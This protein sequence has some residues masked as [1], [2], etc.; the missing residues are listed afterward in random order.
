MSAN[1]MQ[2]EKKRREFTLMEL[3]ESTAKNKII[4]KRFRIVLPASSYL[5]STHK[6]YGTSKC[7]SQASNVT[8]KTL[9]L[10]NERQIH[11]AKKIRANLRAALRLRVK[12]ESPVYRVPLEIWSHIFIFCLPTEDEYIDPTPSAAPLVLSRVNGMWRAAATQTPA[13]WTSIRI[14]LQGQVHRRTL[15]EMWF[16]RAGDLPLSIHIVW[17][18]TQSLH[19]HD[20]A[21]EYIHS[22]AHRWR[23]IRL[24]VSKGLV[25]QKHGFPS[26]G[27]RLLA[28]HMPR[29]DTLELEAG[30][31]FG[32][33]NLLR[34][35]APGLRVLTLMNE[36]LNPMQFVSNSLPSTQLTQLSSGF[37]LEI[38]Q[39][40]AIFKNCAN[41]ARCEICVAS[42]PA[43]APPRVTIRMASLQ[44]LTINETS[45]DVLD[46]F[47]HFL[48]LPALHELNIKAETWSL[49]GSAPWTGSELMFLM[50][51]SLEVQDFKLKTLR[52]MG[53][54]CDEKMIKVLVFGIPSLVVFD[55]R[56]RGMELLGRYWV[57]LVRNSQ[58]TMM[59]KGV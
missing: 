30:L 49:Y 14:R 19:F 42:C 44:T 6:Y 59:S 27:R 9:M 24:S 16:A 5:P 21:L 25:W 4:H 8:A 34:E 15:L 23:R 54:R 33:T 58:R 43:I 26:R 53:L 3:V 39:A 2:L 45:A 1:I 35:N 41:L 51:R 36:S 47:F 22:L 57:E 55:I 50:H 48:E 31:S 37:P 28:Q 10:E 13:L 46:A 56:H 17:G 52:V 20:N 40:F 18:P 12:L 29:L 32:V 38:T 7:S 11:W